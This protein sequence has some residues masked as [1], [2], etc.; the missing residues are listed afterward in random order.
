MDM[1]V[2]HHLASVSGGVALRNGKLANAPPKFTNT[3]SSN[4]ILRSWMALFPA[5]ARFANSRN[6]RATVLGAHD[7]ARNSDGHLCAAAGFELTCRAAAIR[8]LRLLARYGWF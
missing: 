3:C 5:R 8:F 1:A 6:Q 7:P 4:R 2:V